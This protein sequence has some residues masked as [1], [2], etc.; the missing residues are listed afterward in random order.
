MGPTQQRTKC[1]I[2]VKGQANKRFH[3]SRAWYKSGPISLAFLGQI[4]LIK[5]RKWLKIDLE[6][7][8]SHIEKPSSF[9]LVFGNHSIICLGEALG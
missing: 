7:K 5:K 1:N 3:Y 9:L 2:G 4:N 6:E 8:S